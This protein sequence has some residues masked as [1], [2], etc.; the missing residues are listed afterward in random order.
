MVKTAK[1]NFN[2]LLSKN[3]R[4]SGGNTKVIADLTRTDDCFLIESI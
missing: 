4:L 1:Q 3:N 2:I